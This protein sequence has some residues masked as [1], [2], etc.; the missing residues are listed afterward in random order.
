MASRDFPDLQSLAQRAQQAKQDL[1]AAR[2]E[3]AQSF[4]EGVAGGGAV[5]AIISGTGELRDLEISPSLIDPGQISTLTEMIISAIQDAQE[6][7][8]SMQRKR[9]EPLANMFNAAAGG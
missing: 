3:L 8:K 5:R 6:S 9:L 4:V 7:L 1:A 2:L